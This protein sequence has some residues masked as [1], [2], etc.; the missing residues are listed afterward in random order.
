MHESP[1]TR[2]CVSLGFARLSN[3]HRKQSESIEKSV[4]NMHATLKII[5]IP[6]LASAFHALYMYARCWK[7]NPIPWIARCSEKYNRLS[8]FGGAKFVSSIMVIFKRLNKSIE[9][10]MGKMSFQE[11]IVKKR[12]IFCSSQRF[13]FS[14]HKYE[15]SFVLAFFTHLFATA[16]NQPRKFFNM[17]LLNASVAK[18]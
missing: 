18:W 5:A 1:D 8:S 2:K 6:S 16:E 15:M 17:Q 10:K 13:I 9:V 11:T 4:Q 3:Q 14:L 12:E 7:I